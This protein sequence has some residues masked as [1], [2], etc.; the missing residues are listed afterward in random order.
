MY[1]TPWSRKES[2]NGPD[3]PREQGHQTG[4]TGSTNAA[5]HG[6]D[7]RI[8]PSE[9]FKS[10]LWKMASGLPV[11]RIVILDMFKMFCFVCL[12]EG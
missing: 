8:L 4:P 10:L 11:R 7:L 2:S 9:K 5:G 12:P 1:A 6:E 3:E